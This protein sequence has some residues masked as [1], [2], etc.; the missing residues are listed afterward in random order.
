MGGEGVQPAIPPFTRRQLPPG[1]IGDIEI[2]I[3]DSLPSARRPANLAPLEVEIREASYSP[4]CMVRI[5]HHD[6]SGKADG[7]TTTSVVLSWIC[8]S[9]TIILAAPAPYAPRADIVRRHWRIL[10]S[11]PPRRCVLNMRI[12]RNV[13]Q[14][15]S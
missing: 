3:N 15:M 10:V 13:W 6:S 9:G 5:G 1:L 2:L 8:E 12:R 14:L 4:R 11:S 7:W